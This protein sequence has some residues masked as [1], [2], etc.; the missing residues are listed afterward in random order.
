[1]PFLVDS[2]TMELTAQQRNIHV[3]VHPQFVVT[4]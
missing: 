4:P 3:I 2:V 1:M